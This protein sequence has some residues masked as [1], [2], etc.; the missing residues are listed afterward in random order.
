M[1]FAL[2]SGCRALD[3]A[4]RQALGLSGREAA[5]FTFSGGCL[6][7]D[8]QIRSVKPTSTRSPAN[9]SRYQFQPFTLT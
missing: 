7:L 9:F 1:D 4:A 8:L 6:W 3:C 5:V 2:D